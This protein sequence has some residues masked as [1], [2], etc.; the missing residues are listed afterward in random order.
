MSRKS[1]PSRGRRGRGG[2]PARDPASRRVGDTYSH[3]A[4]EEGYAARSVYKL[5]DIDERLHLLAPGQRVLDLGC[6]PGSWLKYAAQRVGREGRVVGIDLVPTPAPAAWAE[7]IAGDVFC[8]DPATL[9]ERGRFDAVL[10]DMAPSTTGVQVTD[11]ARS[12]ALAE[13]ALAI[14]CGVLRPGGL[15]LI[16]VFTGED[17][18]LLETKIRKYFSMFSRERP[19]AVRQQSREIYLL[20]RGFV[21]DTCAC[22]SGP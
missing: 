17:L 3:R 4:R 6:H 14:A 15:L 21:G 7:V 9:A 16:K 11:H 20:G 2:L 8:W 10:S 12:M 13:R 18:R 1:Q 5:K 22:T 19:A